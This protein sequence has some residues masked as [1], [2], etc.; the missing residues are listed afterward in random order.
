MIKYSKSFI[1]K[2]KDLD[3]G[4]KCAGSN[5]EIF[6]FITPDITLASRKQARNSKPVHSW[7][8][9]R[10][11]FFDGAQGEDIVPTTTHSSTEGANL[12]SYANMHSGTRQIK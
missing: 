1:A 11:L 10:R 3:H 9:N 4:R 8:M 5:F 12:A 7:Y 2:E 6:V